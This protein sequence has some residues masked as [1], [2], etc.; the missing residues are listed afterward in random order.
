MRSCSNR[1]NKTRK[2]TIEAKTGIS[3]SSLE[4]GCDLCLQRLSYK[5]S[6][7][8]IKKDEAQTPKSIFKNSFVQ[9]SHQN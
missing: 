9:K 8:L 3:Y 1:S 5:S 2:Q 7:K 4:T 6:E